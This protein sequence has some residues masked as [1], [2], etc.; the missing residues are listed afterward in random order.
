MRVV[1]SRRAALLDDLAASW[2]AAP[3]R[4]PEL[5][6]ALLDAPDDGRVKLFITWRALAARRRSPALAGGSSL[7]LTVVGARADHVVAFARLAHP[8]AHPAGDASTTDAAVVVAPRL[9]VGLAGGAPPLGEA[10]WGDTSLVLPPA[11]AGRRWRCALTDRAHEP[12]ARLR[13]GDLLSDLPG[14]LLL[15]DWHP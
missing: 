13:L 8:G 9:M 4:R 5:A 2:S 3:R 10:V 14:A 6:R 7:P 12:D 11:L 15:P 1:F